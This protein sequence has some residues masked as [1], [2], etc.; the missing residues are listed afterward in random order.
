MNIAVVGAGY[1]G[2]NVIR[3]FYLTPKANLVCICDISTENLEKIKKKYSDVKTTTIYNDVLDD[4]TIDAVS[5]CTPAGT[6][7]RLAKKALEKGKHVLIEKPI[8]ETS[9]QAKLLVEI[10]AEMNLILMV[11]HIFIYNPAVQKLKELVSN[12]YFGE[13]RHI[14]SS[15]T[16]LGPRVRSDVNVV[17]DYLI[18]D[19]YIMQYLL[20]DK[21]I[22]INPYSGCYLQRN[23]EDVVFV[24]MR[25]KKDIFVNLNAA[26]YDP[27][28]KR[29][30]VIIG[31]KKMACYDE[32]NNTGKIKIYHCGFRRIEG[33]DKFGNENL[34]LYDDG[35][36]CI[37]IPN[38]E[39]LLLE[40]EHFIDCINNHSFPITDGSSGKKTIEI[41]EIID[42]RLKQLGK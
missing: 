28:K 11:G 10:A 2:P 9:E 24:N 25:F 35:V 7:Y 37:N 19:I 39:A 26:W 4:P 18:H 38:E 34:E 12:N 30:M 40:I 41:L 15:R 14:Y 21:P 33:R 17:W 8:S 31:S 42:K 32:M 23:I 20:N 36:E 27:I 22:D 13:I 3:N 5:L 16:S 6:H 1:W 29:K